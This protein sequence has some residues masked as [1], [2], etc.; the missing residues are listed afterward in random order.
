MEGTTMAAN[1]LIAALETAVPFNK[2]VGLEVLE[3]ERG[4]GAVRL[5]ERPEL[6]NHVGSQHAGA[7]FALAEAASGAAVIGGF[8]DVLATATP[9]AKA[10]EI[11]YERI[12]R[13]PITGRS[14]LNGDLDA[15]RAQLE[16]DGRVAFNVDVTMADASEQ[17]VATMTVQWH[18]AKRK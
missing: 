4:H 15:L 9:L 13:G 17:T 16:A 8:A 6:L 11:R 1:P 18:V 14:Q 2:L 12:A 10:A 7:L 5:P 3:V